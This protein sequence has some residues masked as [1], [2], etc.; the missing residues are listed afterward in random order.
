MTV[1][2]LPICCVLLCGIAGAA[3]PPFSG[4]W[5]LDESRSELRGLP[6]KPAAVMQLDL[7]GSSMTCE[8]GDVAEKCS[9]TID[10][11]ESRHQT[12]G[13][14]HSRVAKWEGD[15]IIL[16]TIVLK[17][18]GQHSEQDR[19][20]VSRDGAT[21]RIRRRIVGLHGETESLLVYARE[22][23]QAA[24]KATETELKARPD[25]IAAAVAQE[26]WTVDKGTKIPLAIINSI[27]TKNSAAGDRIYL[28]TVYPIMVEGRMVIPP[29]SFVNGTVTDVKRP[30]K[31]KG[32][33]ALYIRFDAMILPNG[34]TRDFRARVG[35]L[36]GRASEQ[37]DREEGRIQSEGNKSG[38]ARNAGEAAAAGASVGV[39]VGSVAGRPGMGA[40]VGA[41]AGAAAALVGILMT[42]GPEAQLAAGSIVEMVL[43]RNLQFT[44]E[45]LGR[46]AIPQGQIMVP[47]SGP[48]PSVRD[49]Q[50]GI[51]IPGR[52]LPL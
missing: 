3:D 12:S 38:D 49:R 25:A 47:G 26:A 30:G 29:G 22:G 28:Q 37:L 1:T 2:R 5:Q 31:V 41:A 46:P 34:T 45:E 10:R 9:F 17:P 11:K 24:A 7:Q 20:T 21:L 33:G 14:T 32:R 51:P 44:A 4:K 27:S 50:G 39:L 8:A 40:G 18:G 36:D 13:G 15:A 6:D 48:A 43:D 52:R 35:S 42:R 23:A 19:W 16:S